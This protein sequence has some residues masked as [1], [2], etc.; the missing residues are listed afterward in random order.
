MHKTI[1][2]VLLILAVLAFAG[3]AIWFYKDQNWEPLVGMITSLAAIIGLVFSGDGGNGQ[4]PKKIVQK[5]KGGDGSTNYQAGG[6]I[7]IG[8]K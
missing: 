2:L 5:Q 6:S 8:K 3:T 7:N 4:N 1:K